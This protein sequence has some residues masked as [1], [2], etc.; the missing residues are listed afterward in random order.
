M[1]ELLSL[2]TLVLLL[3]AYGF[4]KLSMSRFVSENFFPS[5]HFI[6]RLFTDFTA[7]SMTFTIVHVFILEFTGFNL[8]ES[9]IRFPYSFY[10]LG[11]YLLLYSWHKYKKIS[12]SDNYRYIK[13]I[14]KTHASPLQELTKMLMRESAL[15]DI[16]KEK[17]SLLKSLSPI[18][19]ALLVFNNLPTKFVNAFEL[20]SSVLQNQINVCLLLTLGIYSYIT[21]S[22]FLR[23]KQSI[24]TIFYINQEIYE[25]NHPESPATTDTLSIS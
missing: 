12:I 11:G 24:T 17:F 18:P 16:Q 13:S 4:D 7:Q 9:I 8:C 20:V 14:H 23:I 25:I 3:F 10:I 22:T 15:L 2:I 6:H 1:I 5:I 21:T 19:V